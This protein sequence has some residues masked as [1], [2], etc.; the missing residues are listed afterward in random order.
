MLTG[1][2]LIWK[3]YK[4]DKKPVKG[5]LKGQGSFSGHKKS[6]ATVEITGFLYERRSRDLNYEESVKQAEVV[7]CGVLYFKPLVMPGGVG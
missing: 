3:P 4:A 2:R 5:Q 1:C 7:C 6:P